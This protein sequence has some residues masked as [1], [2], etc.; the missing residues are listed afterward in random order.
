MTLAYILI[1]VYNGDPS[2]VAE[3]LIEIPEIT[4]AVA[5]MAVL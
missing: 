4:M 2:K 5:I 3:E 1:S